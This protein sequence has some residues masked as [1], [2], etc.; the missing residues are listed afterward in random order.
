MA[1]S[2]LVGKFP[3]ANFLPSFRKFTE[4]STKEQKVDP[5]PQDLLSTTK[6][7]AIQPAS[8]TIIVKFS[9]FSCTWNNFL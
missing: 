1:A 8:Y 4:K 9:Q 2:S 5:E 6:T 7:I 3:G